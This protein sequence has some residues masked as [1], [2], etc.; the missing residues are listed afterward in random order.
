MD[1]LIE[2][3]DAPA[4]VASVIARIGTPDSPWL[5]D[6]RRQPAYDADPATPAAALRCAPH[7]IDRAA[8]VLP[9]GAEV[10][11]V[12][13]HGH[14]VSQAAAARLRRLGLRARHLEGGLAAWRDA[15][16]PVLRR[17]D[18]L[19]PPPLGG[20]CWVTRERPKI[21]RIAC[22]WLVLRFVDP[23]ARFV[24]LPA[25]EVVGF[26]KATGAISFDVP[27]GDIGH[28]GDLCSFDVLLREIGLVRRSGHGT[29]GTTGAETTGA[30]TTGAETTGGGPTAA[31]P[32]GPPGG[33]AGAL[34]RLA[35]IVRGADTGRPA[36]TA[37]SAGLLAI[38]L[39][40]S[41]AI[42]DDARMLA[43]ALPIYDALHAWCR[44]AAGQAHGTATV[45]Q[46]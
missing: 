18:R 3:F 36:L 21:D 44:D 28:D 1:T 34:E 32:G 12:C 2:P 7:D 29:T 13:V 41:R 19:S 40:L 42:P 8:L 25:D 39:G 14:E 37:Q 6:V 33:A 46:P 20:S 35:A 45:P 23:R 17:H 27:G 26:A 22:P 15:H 16:G 9:A 24:Y 10:V 30:E 43:T 11:C 4:S 5:L 38:S 31:G